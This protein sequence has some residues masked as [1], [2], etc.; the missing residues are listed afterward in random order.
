[1]SARCCVAVALYCILQMCGVVGTSGTQSNASV[2]LPE[3]VDVFQ[4]MTLV[5]QDEH[6]DAH[7]DF[8]ENA[9]KLCYKNGTWAR[10][11]NYIDNCHP[12]SASTKPENAEMERHLENAKQLNNVG[13]AISL[14]CLVIAFGLFAYLK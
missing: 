4:L 9:T 7:I 3:G 5:C 13:H 10:K 6:K 2:K 8:A 11:A 12:I 14:V 1:M